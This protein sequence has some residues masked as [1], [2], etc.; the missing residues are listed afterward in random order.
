MRCIGAHAKRWTLESDDPGPDALPTLTY[1]VRLKKRVDLPTLLD[2][3][4]NRLGPNLAEYAPAV[5]A[6][7]RDTVTTR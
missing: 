5:P 3:L 4:R 6:E 7:E 1:Q 2:A